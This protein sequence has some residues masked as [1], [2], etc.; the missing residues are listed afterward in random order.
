MQQK[1]STLLKMAREALTKAEGN[2]VKAQEYFDQAML[3]T[4]SAELERSLC[5]RHRPIE[6]QSLIFSVSHEMRNEGN[7]S[8]LPVKT[9]PKQAM[10]TEWNPVTKHTTAGLDAVLKVTR[11]SCLM[12]VMINGRVLGYH[13]RDELDDYIRHVD[14]VH[15][16]KRNLCERL[17]S[18]I[19]PGTPGYI[20]NY[21]SDEE[22]DKHYK[23]VFNM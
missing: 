23:E 1:D 8:P 11:K 18:G 12:T 10:I 19:V 15:I 21:I 5:Q 17:I 7:L 14:T 9:F 2:T 6:I 13:T 16:P 3:D 4:N 20:S 22:A